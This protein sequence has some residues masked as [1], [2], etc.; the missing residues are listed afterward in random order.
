[1][2]EIEEENRRELDLDDKFYRRVRNKGYE[3]F[4]APS[5]IDFLNEPE[6]IEMPIDNQQ[7]EVDKNEEE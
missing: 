2:S 6:E 4:K 5:D 3:K 1:L 7:L